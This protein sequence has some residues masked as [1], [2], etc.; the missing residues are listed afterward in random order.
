MRM[1]CEGYTARGVLSWQLNVS[2]EQASAREV[3]LVVRGMK[4]C[5]NSLVVLHWWRSLWRC[6]ELVRLSAGRSP[7]LTGVSHIPVHDLAHQS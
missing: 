7:R 4:E 1:R 3:M 2:R 6:M 5:S